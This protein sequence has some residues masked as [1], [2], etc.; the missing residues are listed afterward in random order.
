VSP[1]QEIPREIQVPAGARLVLRAHA[2]GVQIYVCQQG[3]DGKAVWILKGPEATLSDDRGETIGRH[4]PGPAWK[5]NDGSE[6]T[7]K[8]TSRVNSPSPD[9]IPW[10]LLKVINHTG[11]GVLGTV[12]AIQ[13]VATLGGLPP[14]GPCD[15]SSL[16]AEAASEYE[17]EYLFYAGE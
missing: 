2:S 5:H 7:A 17:A 8:V 6:V 11:S 9:S 14:A 15:S 10:L 16:G 1:G 12:T 4:Y 3:A 13:R